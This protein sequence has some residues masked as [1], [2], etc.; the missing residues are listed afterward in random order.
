M[1][2]VIEVKEHYETALETTRIEVV[3]L[4]ADV[5]TAISSPEIE[6]VEQGIIVIPAPAGSGGSAT[7]ERLE[8]VVPAGF[9]GA[10]T[11]PHTPIPNSVN[12]FLN[13]LAEFNFYLTGQT[14]NIAFSAVPGDSLII[15]YAR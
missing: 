4:G 5:Q 13:G 7:Y 10:I 11:L 14:L 1:I 9:S 15:T 2:E 12:V 6:L 3:E 8:I